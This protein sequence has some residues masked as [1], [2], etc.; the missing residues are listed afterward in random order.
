MIPTPLNPQLNSTDNNTA[1]NLNKRK[2]NK[3]ARV[4]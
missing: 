2:R 1:P 4:K 3:E